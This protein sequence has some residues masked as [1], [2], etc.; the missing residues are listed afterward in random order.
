VIT[1]D[2]VGYGA[3]RE[4]VFSGVEELAPD[5][6]AACELSLLPIVLARARQYLEV[7]TPWVVIA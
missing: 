1:V 7:L 6:R 5:E 3:I 4:L 2:L